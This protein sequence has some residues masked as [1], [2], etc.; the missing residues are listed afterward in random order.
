MS[1]TEGQLY[2]DLRERFGIGD[3][4][5]ATSTVPFYKYRMTEISKIKAMMKKRRVTVD[6]L[7]L[8]AD[9]AQIHHL[10]VVALWRVFELVPDAL[11]AQRE[12]NRPSLHDEVWAAVD[13]AVAAGEQGWADRLMAAANRETLDAWRDRG[14]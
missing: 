11:R 6:Q 12:S 2:D 9:Y 4:D 1:M 7:L 8:A 13:E 10:P 3:W 14:R 5:E